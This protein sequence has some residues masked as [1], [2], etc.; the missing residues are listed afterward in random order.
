MKSS[1]NSKKILF[2]QVMIGTI[3][4]FI[5]TIIVILIL[6]LKE[7]IEVDFKLI[8]ESQIVLNLN[9][10]YQEQGFKLYV[11]GEQENNVEIINE[12]N[13][14]VI[15]DYKIIYKY[16]DK[17]QKEYLFYRNVKIVD[18]VNPEI[19]LEG[20]DTVYI[21]LNKEY[22]EPGYYAKDNYDG[23]ITD[24]VVV[25]NNIDITKLGEYYVKYIV[26]DSSGNNFEIKRTVVVVKPKPVVTK[27]ESKGYEKKTN[28]SYLTSNYD[29]TI[30]YNK[31]TNQGIY[32]E[33][34]L[35]DSGS[36]VVVRFVNADTVV[37]FPMNVN[38]NYYSGTINT[39]NIPNGN[40]EIYVIS[41]NEKRL[42][43]KMEDID[44]IVR[45]KI[46]DK[47]VTINYFDDLVNVSIENFAYAYDILIDVGHGGS[48]NGASNIYAYEKDINLEVSLYEKCRYEEHGLRVL[49]NRT[50]DNYGFVMGS[51]SWNILTQRAYALGYY[52]TVSKIA[53]SNHHN[54]TT[55][56]AASGFEILTP[57]HYNNLSTEI[58]IANRFFNF[59]PLQ[60][61]HKRVY[62]RNY[63]NGV[64][65][66]T[67]NF[68]QY[69]IKDYYCIIRVP[70]LL[71]N[72]KMVIYEGIYM[73]NAS[74]F[75]WYYL[76]GN[77][78]K[79]SE[80][81]IQNYVESLGIVYNPST[82]C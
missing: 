39:D 36:N 63:E 1:G 3:G 68:E 50:N 69:D 47:L 8:G 52:G 67:L 31:F 25:E 70:Y 2:K 41:N 72:T 62:A 33:G 74:D 61:N 28:V 64:M 11:N 19:V 58:N 10:E 57:S 81:K 29:N 54:S 20:N 56:K 40:Y 14:Q 77:W 17:Y 7:K 42:Q 13:N 37:D 38:G 15:G 30:V 12:I 23:D 34:Y 80:I 46:G 53:Y 44:R 79:V 71:F 59:Y 9:E 4:I 16:T 6:S 27:T 82:G 66:S 51:G 48:D 32:Y 43:N 26:T 45:S 24:K 49:M 55:N 60:E 18:K 65:L 75:N 22:Q 73:S 5:T 35:L 76:N 21:V 78:K